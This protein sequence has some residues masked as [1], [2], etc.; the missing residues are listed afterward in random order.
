MKKIK[1]LLF[2]A[3]EAGVKAIQN[4]SSKVEVIGFLDNNP[5]KWNTTLNHKIV[6]SPNDLNKLDYDFIVITSMYVSQIYE[7]LSKLKID[8]EKILT[9]IDEKPNEEPFPWDAVFF[10]ISFIIVLSL[11]L[12]LIP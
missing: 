7:Q 11:I 2:G 6:Y 12:T 1:I 3:S 8:P 10:I 9:G 5:Q 4:T